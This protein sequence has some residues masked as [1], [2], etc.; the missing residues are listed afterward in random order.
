MTWALWS[1]SFG[2]IWVRQ[3]PCLPIYLILRNVIVCHLSSI[4]LRLGLYM[5]FREEDLISTSKEGT[6]S[7]FRGSEVSSIFGVE[8]H[9]I[10]YP[11]SRALGPTISLPKQ[12]VYF[13]YRS[14]ILFFLSFFYLV[15]IFKVIIFKCCILLMI[16]LK[17]CVISTCHSVSPFSN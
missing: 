14:V 4:Y 2:V 5:V 6:I 10:R 17:K 11:C 8:T 15:Y 1:W 16:K 13:Q 7:E 3:Q 9:P 12:I